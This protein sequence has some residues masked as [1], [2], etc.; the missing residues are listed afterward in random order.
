MNQSPDDILVMFEGEIPTDLYRG[1]KGVVTASLLHPLL[2][3]KILPNGKRREPDIKSF[4]KDG[5]LWVKPGDGGS[6]LFDRPGLFRGNWSYFKIPKGTPIRHGLKVSET[7]F[8]PPFGA[9]HY[10]ISP[11]EPMPLSAFLDLLDCLR[12]DAMA[13]PNFG[14]V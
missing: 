2:E 1:F 5:A 9:F 3:E 13:H 4:M 12:L 8:S 10:Q 14:I 6:S 7:H 11:S